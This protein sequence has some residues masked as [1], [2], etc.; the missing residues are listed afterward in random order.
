MPEFDYVIGLLEAKGW[1]LYRGIPLAKMQEVIALG[2][3]TSVEPNMFYHILPATSHDKDV[4]EVQAATQH[5][6][7]TRSMPVYSDGGSQQS[8]SGIA[9]SEGQFSFVTTSESIAFDAGSRSSIEEAIRHNLSSYNV[10]YFD[11]IDA[12]SSFLK[13]RNIAPQKPLV[14][15]SH[16][17]W[18]YVEIEGEPATFALYPENPGE[19]LFRGQTERYL[20]CV[21]TAVRGI[22]FG[23][24]ALDE[25]SEPN[26]ARLIVNLIKTSWFVQLLRKTAVVEWFRDKRLYLNEAAVAQHYGMPTGYIDL[27]QSFEVASFFACCHYDSAQ[28]SW[29]PVADGEGVVYALGWGSLPP[30]GRIHPINLQA[31]PRPSEQ[32]GW[33]CEVA[34]GDDFD[35]LPFVVKLIFRHN[36]DASRRILGQFSGGGD[37]YPADPLAELAEA[38]LAATVLPYDLAREMALDLIGDPNGKPGSTLEDILALIQRFN[39]I[40]VSRKA[41]I[42]GWE[43][44]NA[45]MTQIWERVKPSLLTGSSPGSNE[46]AA[47]GSS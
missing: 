35:K 42:A 34:L 22:G 40:Q 41:S 9:V 10:F 24:R 18:T 44:M 6:V 43:R 36:L 8:I 15:P 47:D 14:E 4:D 19:M 33:S 46:R 12:I 28:K 25:L 27:T 23:S 39:G 17:R 7:R 16:L 1:Y 11:S 29:T 21:P 30:G 2:R 5:A 38:I 32:W 37:L 45:A 26:Q 20:P 3:A 13:S 31:F